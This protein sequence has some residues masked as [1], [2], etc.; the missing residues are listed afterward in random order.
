MP[1]KDLTLMLLPLK[2]VQNR[3][4]KIRIA[5]GKQLLD[6][7]VAPLTDD[8]LALCP[9]SKILFLR[10]DSKIGDLIVS[11][12]VFR[13]IKKNDPTVKI[14]IVCAPK[15]KDL[16]EGNPYI[17]YFHAASKITLL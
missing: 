14:G 2:I 16:L 4:Q 7:P 17:D 13:E 9:V 11:S 5:I 3:L 6:K 10:K 15:N 1:G 12:F 8:P